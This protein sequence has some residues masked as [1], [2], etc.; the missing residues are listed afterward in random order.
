MVLLA[1][2]L[3]ATLIW[4]Y[5]CR[6]RNKQTTD[7]EQAIQ[8][9]D[10]DNEVE[11]MDFENPTLHNEHQPA[12]N[13][14]AGGGPGTDIT[15][16]DGI[17]TV[18]LPPP[19]PLRNSTGDVEQRLSGKKRLFGAAATPLAV[20][21]D[22]HSGVFKKRSTKATSGSRKSRHSGNNPRQFD[23]TDNGKVATVIQRIVGRMRNKLSS[24]KW[25]EMDGRSAAGRDQQ[26][27]DITLNMPVGGGQM[28]SEK[29]L[30]TAMG[31]RRVYIPPKLHEPPRG[32]APAS[33]NV[34]TGLRSAWGRVKSGKKSSEEG[35][36]GKTET[37]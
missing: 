4:A 2:L 3:L 28:M 11:W 35:V 30:K 31:K 17:T 26:P 37:A 5:R 23:L 21:N 10:L 6:G 16:S 14:S 12:A 8:D 7:S 36:E 34:P 1:L 27:P 33:H 13:P 24:V 29:G 20:V 19:V 22:R 32:W 25:T 9:N 15:S 18:S